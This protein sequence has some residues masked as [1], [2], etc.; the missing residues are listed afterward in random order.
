MIYDGSNAVAILDKTETTATIIRQLNALWYLDFEYVYNP[1]DPTN[2]SEFIVEDQKVRVVDPD[3]PSTYS[4]FK[5]LDITKA[6][7]QSSFISIQVKAQ[8]NAISTM[9]KEMVP[10]FL[11]F[12]AETPTNI[13]AVIMQ[14]STFTAGTVTPTAKIDLTLSYETVL[15]AVRKLAEACGCYWDF[16]FAT[17]QAS[18]LSSIGADNG[19]RI[20]ADHNLRTISRTAYN[21]ETLTKIYGVGGGEP[22][23]TIAGAFHSVGSVTSQTITCVGNKIV[24][25]NDFWNTSYQIRVKTGSHANAVRTITDCVHGTVSDTLT[26]SGDI[27]SLA[28]GDVF[29]IETTGST[30]VGFIGIGTATKAGVHSNGNWQAISNYVKTPALDGTYGSGLCANW[31]KVGTPTVTENTTAAY[32]KYG[33]KSQRVQ[34]TATVEGVKQ[35]VVHNTPNELWSITATVYIAS[36]GVALA[37]QEDVNTGFFAATQSTG[38][39][40]FAIEGI[41]NTDNDLTVFV[42]SAVASSD[43]YVDSVQ[44][45]KTSTAQRFANRC[46]KKKLWDEVF[47]KLQIVSVARVTYACQFADLYRIDPASFPFESIALGDTVNVIDEGLNIN[48]DVKVVEKRDPVFEPE[49]MESVISNG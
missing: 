11:D 38:W 7:K 49:K 19:V 12:K 2:K 48:V 18:I 47:D 33:Q 5:I 15:S 25:V 42:L 8:S 36:G 6:R 45:T 27:S 22:P 41:L 16:D 37:V 29:V 20:T 9:N 3:I 23:T 39:Q 43:F 21:G 1:S 46:E 13:L 28:A 40:T 4:D 30:E 32:I 24:P 35:T 17:G 10:A 31:V 44:I 26:V 14:Y 34:S